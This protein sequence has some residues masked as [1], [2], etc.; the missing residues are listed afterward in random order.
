MADVNPRQ[1]RALVTLAE[2][3]AITGRNVVDLRRWAREG[4]IPATKVGRDW[5]VERDALLAALERI[6]DRRRGGDR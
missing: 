6:Q 1:Y 3:A 5:M 2:A 4:R